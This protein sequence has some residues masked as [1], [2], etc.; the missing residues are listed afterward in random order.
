MKR[1]GMLSLMVLMSLATYADDV[2]SVRVETPKPKGYKGI[3]KAYHKVYD[4]F[5]AFFTNY[6]TTYISPDK[7]NLTALAQNT[8]YIQ[9]YR[10][11]T[12]G[13]DG[14]RI[15]TFRPTPTVSIGPYFGYGIIF[16]GYEFDVV[17]K[18]KLRT[19]WNLSLYTN[20][21]G[22][23]FV[24][25][26]NK[27][28]FTLQ[29]TEGFEGVSKWQYKGT[30]LPNA[31]SKF[32]SLNFYYVLNHKKFSFPAVYS[33]S[34]QQLKSAGS[35]IFGLRFDHQNFFFDNDEMPAELPKQIKDDMDFENIRY[36]CYSLSAGYGYN[37]VFAK[38]WCLGASFAPAIGLTTLKNDDIEDPNKFHYSYNVSFDA[39]GRVG[40]VYNNSKWVAGASLISHLYDYRTKSIAL[41]NSLNY[42]NLYVGYYFWR[43]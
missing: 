43:K 23:D 39:V 1:F 20:P 24:F 37:W 33:Q 29:K 16:G 28:D 9:A 17:G 35:V 10:L 7:Y 11:R 8:N 32:W 40:I 2:D 18:S 31:K 25:M 12:K 14:K 27:G 34:T 15:L 22:V 21:V 4:F 3:A 6:D 41:T 13:E 42:L 19:S 30:K 36:N 5:D 38:N 26:K